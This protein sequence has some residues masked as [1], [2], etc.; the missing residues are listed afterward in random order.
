[1]QVLVE[2]WLTEA[3]YEQAR[4]DRKLAWQSDE[5]EEKPATPA[6]RHNEILRPDADPS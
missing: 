4:S 6:V 1:M 5:E 2:K 3:E